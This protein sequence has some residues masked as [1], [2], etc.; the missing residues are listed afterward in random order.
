MREG[1]NS[2]GCSDAKI[3]K[4]RDD[5]H[6]NYQCSKPTFHLN[7][8][9]REMSKF[10]DGIPMLIQGRTFSLFPLRDSCGGGNVIN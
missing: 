9:A 7:V 10:K 8:G 2:T 6:K 1:G 5:Q 4:K 3:E